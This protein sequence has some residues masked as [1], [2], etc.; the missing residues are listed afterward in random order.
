MLSV[1]YGCWG[2]TVTSTDRASHLPS[3]ENVVVTGHEMHG[4]ELQYCHNNVVTP[5]AS[6]FIFINLVVRN[7]L[8]SDGAICTSTSSYCRLL[9]D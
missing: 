8:G 2:M 6:F 9:L 4:G 3:Q 1:E 5:R 7:K